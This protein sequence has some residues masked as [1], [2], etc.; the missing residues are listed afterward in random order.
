MKTRLIFLLIA[1][2]IPALRGI[3]QIVHGEDVV[4]DKKSD[5]N[6]YAAGGTVSVDAPAMRDV[7]VVGGTVTVSD[8]VGGDVMVAGGNFILKGN[9]SDDVRCAGGK[10]LIS[11]NV[12]GDLLVTG[13]NVTVERDAVVGGNFI[14]SG[15][16]V[17]FNGTVRGKTQSAS[18]EFV[19]NG[20]TQA[21]DCRGGQITVNG[22]VDGAAVLAAN[23]ITLGPAARFHKEVTY[24]N[25]DEALDFKNA[26]AGGGTAVFDPSLEMES[27]KWHYLGFASVLIALWYLGTAL[28]MIVLIQYFFGP[29]LK[30]AAD[31]LKNSAVRSLGMGLL[32]LAG[33]P[34]AIVVVAVTV[35][36]L[37]V[38]ALML[39]GYLTVVLCGTVIVSLVAA[40]WIN[41]TFYQSSWRAGKIVGIAL[42]LFIFLKLPS[43]T[44]F[45]GPLIMLLITCM[46]VGAILQSIRWKRAGSRSPA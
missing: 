5:Q 28:L 13:G 35:I 18:G 39:A 4:I 16:R 29:T 30:H 12:A 42:A 46:S 34:V 45:V 26:L 15:G 24:W 7:V 21:I 3:G 10:I 14:V 11:G 9:A 2:T 8:S 37:P 25:A 1:C 22:T 20:T 6:V 41:N 36:G 23:T 31:T 44:P 27:G 17:T 19:L 43:L 33:V 38:S 32:F 40:H